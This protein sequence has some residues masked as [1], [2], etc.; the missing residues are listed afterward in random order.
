MKQNGLTIALVGAGGPLAQPLLD[1]LKACSFSPRSLVPL[2]LGDA[3]GESLEW[4]E[5]R[6]R[7]EALDEFDF[8]TAQLT[9]FCNRQRDWGEWIS[10]AAGAGSLVIDATGS[11]CLDDSVPLVVP[12]I[13][14]AELGDCFAKNIVAMPDSAAIQLALV[15]RPIQQWI[16]LDRVDITLMQSAASGGPD[17]VHDLARQTALLLNGKPLTGAGEARQSAFNV[18]PATG[19]ILENGYT[20]DELS[21]ARQL[22]RLLEDG[23]LQVNA[24][25][26]RVPVF[27]GDSAVV[28]LQCDGEVEAVS[29]RSCL[30]QAPGLALL[31]GEN[32]PTAVGDA[33]GDDRVW[34]GRVRED[35]G[36]PTRINL[37]V[38]VDNQRKGSVLN[39]V[40][41]AEILVKEYL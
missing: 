4:Q 18:L 2:D 32:F 5:G 33:I 9:L 29:V 11:S 23:R 3:I 16:G 19:P 34:V 17:A 20:H 14:G 26:T 15:L 30:Q 8:S 39:L 6:V 7:I 40:Q 36:D 1:E 31:D 22:Q 12:E 10:R 25:I 28:Q 24:T 27:H 35:L 41:V 21:L 38:V 13:N 37:W